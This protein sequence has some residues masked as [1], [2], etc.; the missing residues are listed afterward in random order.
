MFS[1]SKHGI[2]NMH[3]LNYLQCGGV[4][5]IEAY[6]EKTFYV[7]CFFCGQFYTT[8]EIDLDTTSKLLRVCKQL[9]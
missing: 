6:L 5:M 8:K 2:I 1:L 9:Y 7:N 4:L 3:L